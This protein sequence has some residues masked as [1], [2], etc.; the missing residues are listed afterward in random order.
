M[1]QRIWPNVR[2]NK[3]W[4]HGQL[5]WDNTRTLILVSNLDV[6]F[7]VVCLRL[8]Y[9]LPFISPFISYHIAFYSE[10]YAFGYFTISYPPPHCDTGTQP[11]HRFFNRFIYR[12]RHWFWYWV[13][14]TAA[15][16]LGSGAAITGLTFLKSYRYLL[17]VIIIPDQATR[18][19]FFGTRNSDFQKIYENEDINGKL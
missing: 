6:L 18:F 8:F 16:A 14:C 11:A 13:W 3:I 7:W 10:W 15:I 12:Y 19:C 17:V 5:S 4:A 1:N 9:N 2:W